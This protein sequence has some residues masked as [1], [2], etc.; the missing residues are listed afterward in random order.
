MNP[1]PFVKWA[2]GKVRILKV[3][4]SR[5]PYE[6]E[7]N[8]IDKYIEPFVGG[9]ALFFS[10][11]SKYDIDEYL[12]NDKNRILMKT[13]EVIKEKPEKLIKKLLQLEDRYL[14]LNIRKREQMYYDQRD[15]FNS[16]CNKNSNHNEVSSCS[17]F[18]FLNKTCY[19][20]IFRLNQKSEFNVPFGFYSNPN[21]CDEE[22]IMN[23]YEMLQSTKI[24]CMDFKKLFSKIK[25]IGPT[26]FVYFDPPYVI[27]NGNNGFL[28]Y[29][30][31]IF[32][33]ED[34]I[35]MSRLI[36][37]LSLK[38][39]KIMISNANHQDIL[40]LYSDYAIHKAKRYSVIGA[41]ISSRR[42]ISEIIIT[43]YESYPDRS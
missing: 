35:R 39:V 40:R 2:G 5:L 29:N 1:K 11:A 23:A 37:K 31:R 30:E 7:N 18:I 4:Q 41:K 8:E 21:I 17:L 3:L 32:S 10:I 13:Y 27:Q 16:L 20:G 38:G 15:L 43:T 33:W 6:I 12:I 25:K 42:K 26:T 22:N 14:N 9:G 36:D 19:N 28:K 34:Q 24:F